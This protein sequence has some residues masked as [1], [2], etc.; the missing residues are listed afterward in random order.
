MSVNFISLVTC[1]GFQEEPQ[2]TY[3]MSL[4]WASFIADTVPNEQPPQCCWGP[5][6]SLRQPPVHQLC[7]VEHPSNTKITKDD[8]DMGQAQ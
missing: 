5:I 6:A 8:M 2:K 7:E 3:P 1:L 4:T